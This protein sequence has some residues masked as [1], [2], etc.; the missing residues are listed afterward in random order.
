MDAYVCDRCGRMI[1]SEREKQEGRRIK[2]WTLEYFNEKQYAEHS[3]YQIL[4]KD[5]CSKC[6]A[7]LDNFMKE[8]K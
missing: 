6:Y 4:Q 2:I 3:S 7:A 5:L 1:L 8:V